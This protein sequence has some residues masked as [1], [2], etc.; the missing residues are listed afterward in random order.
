MSFLSRKVNITIL[1]T[2]VTLIVC[3]FVYLQFRKN[4]ALFNPMERDIQPVIFIFSLVMIIITF[5]FTAMAWK[6]IL[7]SMG[8]EVKLPRAF[9]IMFL[10]NMGKYI[11]GKVW[12]ALGIVYLSEKSGIPKSVAVTSFV[13][14]EVLITPVALLISSM[15][16]IFSGGLFGRFTVVYGTIGIVLSILL[17]WA[18]I[19]RPIYVQRPI[20]YLMR[21]LK[22]E[23]INFDFAKRKMVSIEFVYLLVWV[24][25]GVSFLFFGYSILKIPHSLIIPLITIYIAAYIIG[26]LSFL[27]PGGLGVREGVLIFMLTP[28][29]RPGEAALLA[30]GSRFWFILGE[31][32]CSIIA[33]LIR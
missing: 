30:V 16:I 33:A 4:Y 5:I 26:Y 27:T 22:Q 11:P 15:Y 8:Y 20:N 14:T 19:F 9:R 23:A 10:S 25:L 7:R 32:I 13:L 2:I 28:I 6:M 18:L 31:I 29:M 17:I 1:K 12:Q 24:S 21:K 3:Y